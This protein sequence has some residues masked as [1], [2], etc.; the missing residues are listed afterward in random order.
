MLGEDLLLLGLARLAKT[1]HQHG[2]V[3]GNQAVIIRRTHKVIAAV[4]IV[5]VGVPDSGTG[6]LYKL[7]L[8]H[9]T[10]PASH[11]QLPATTNC[12]GLYQ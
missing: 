7:V 8:L 2:A 9:A 4:R 11:N 6:P 5:E 3:S 12:R 10:N 1:P